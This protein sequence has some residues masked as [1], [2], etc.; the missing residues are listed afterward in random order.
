[1]FFHL[2][3][4]L[5]LQVAII[6]VT[7]RLIISV[8]YHGS[9]KYLGHSYWTQRYSSLGYTEW[10]GFWNNYYNGR[11]QYERGSTE[12]SGESCGGCHCDEDEQEL[13]CRGSPSLL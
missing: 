13:E 9:Q 3:I 12:T 8:P 4:S 6:I 7:A 2:R 1:M 5:I 11:K 10:D